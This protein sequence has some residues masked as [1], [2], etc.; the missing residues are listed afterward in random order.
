MEQADKFIQIFKEEIILILQKLFQR[1]EKETIR[2]LHRTKS[3]GGRY[4]Y[5]DMDMDTYIDEIKI[6]REKER[7]IL[8]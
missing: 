3:I 5:I 2:I 8:F 1:K 4:R 6:Y 7:K